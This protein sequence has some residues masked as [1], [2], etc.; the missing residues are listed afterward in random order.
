M[1]GE[2]EMKGGENETK[3]KSLTA[4]EDVHDS[5]NNNNTKQHKTQKQTPPLRTDE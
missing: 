4:G 1:R 2:Q 3:S 5:C